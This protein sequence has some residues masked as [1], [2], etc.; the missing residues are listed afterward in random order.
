MAN[1]KQAKDKPIPEPPKFN[2]EDLPEPPKIN[3]SEAKDLSAP[4]SLL[5][6]HADDA[7]KDFD[8]DLKNDFPEMKTD[9]SL[10]SQL[11]PP[12]AEKKGFFSK[13]FSKKEKA[14]KVDMMKSLDLPAP[15]AATEEKVDLAPIGDDTFAPPGSRPEVPEAKP[16]QVKL[17]EPPEESKEGEEYDRDSELLEEGEH[18]R[19]QEMLE[20]G[21]KYLEETP[22][23]TVVGIGAVKERQL[24]K[25]GIKTAEHLA[26]HDFRN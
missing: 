23:S 17:E 26:K 14:E 22:L 18:F 21:E 19:E 16:A 7:S 5:T 9:V 13:L 2:L 15:P 6:E 3:L 8:I 25:A 1:N 11:P 12:K 10:L 4:M 20:E 24:K